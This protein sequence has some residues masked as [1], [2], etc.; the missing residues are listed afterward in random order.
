MI[1]RIEHGT[2][3]SANSEKPRMAK[4]DLPRVPDQDVQSD[5]DDGV[6]G[7][8][9]EKIGKVVSSNQGKEGQGGKE[10]QGPK[11][12]H[13]ALE[14]PDVLIMIPFHIHAPSMSFVL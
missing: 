9:V 5:G 12:G 7:D 1:D 8:E 10:Y 4:G 14:K 11:Q 3:V 6:D 13:L 2:S